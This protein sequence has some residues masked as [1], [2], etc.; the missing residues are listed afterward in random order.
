MQPTIRSPQGDRW[1]GDCHHSESLPWAW[2]IMINNILGSC[3][4]TH[5]IYCIFQVCQHS[6]SIW[7]FIWWFFFCWLVV[8]AGDIEEGWWDFWSRQQGLVYRI[9]WTSQSTSSFIGWTMPVIGRVGFDFM[10]IFRYRQ[11]YKFFKW[12]YQCLFYIIYFA[13]TIW[14][15]C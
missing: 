15:L 5:T 6:G 8:T 13:E 12:K 14:G 10:R 2:E 9:W 7:L 4:Q 11:T 3:L 1:Q